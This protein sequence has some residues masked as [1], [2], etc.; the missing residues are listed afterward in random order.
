MSLDANPSKAVY[1]R[2]KVAV[3]L[4]PPE[5]R[6]ECRPAVTAMA[7]QQVAGSV[8]RKSSSIRDLR[9][10]SSPAG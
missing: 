7:G 2:Y 6:S 4:R 10:P 1:Y 3:T 5:A 8:G 9:G